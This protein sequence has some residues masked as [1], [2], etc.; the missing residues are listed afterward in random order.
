MGGPSYRRSTVAFLVA[1]S[2]LVALKIFFD[3]Q[4]VDYALR[5]QGEAFTWQTVLIILAIG[6]AG[7]S[8]TATS[9]FHNL[10]RAG[11]SVLE[12]I[13]A[14][15]YRARR[16]HHTGTQELGIA[17]NVTGWKSYRNWRAE[18]HSNRR[19][20]FLILVPN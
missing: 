16:S 7:F 1:C 18:R 3:L 11:D 15:I 17:A 12:A 20:T 4:P 6:T 8:L 2:V 14:T 10:F 5:D 13:C 9:A 19:Y